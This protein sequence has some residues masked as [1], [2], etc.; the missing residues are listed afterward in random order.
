MKMKLL[1][2]AMF[3][4]IGLAGCT[5]TPVVI[6]TPGPGST[7]IWVPVADPLPSPDTWTTGDRVR[8]ALHSGMGSA[9]S[10]IRVYVDANGVAFL[11]GYVATN[12]DR[13]RARAITQGTVG[14]RSVNYSEL[15]TG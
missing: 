13:E 8:S 15:R 1:A 5:T 2:I 4:T 9:A 12:A 6:D 7:V 14:V 10:R 11:S 3:T